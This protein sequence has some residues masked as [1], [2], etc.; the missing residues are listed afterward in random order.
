MDPKELLKESN[1]TAVNTRDN[2]IGFFEKRNLKR[3]GH[4]DCRRNLPRKDENGIWSAPYI[5]QQKHNYS[6]L[7]NGTYA[8]LQYKNEPVYA[9]LGYLMEAIPKDSEECMR[10]EKEIEEYSSQI[11]T[12]VRKNGES[13]LT[14]AQ[15]V[16]RRTAEKAKALAPLKERQRAV[17]D[18]L[19]SERDEF[20][21]L[22][23]QV[24]EDNNT[25]RLLCNKVRDHI[26]QRIAVYWDAA[27][28][29]DG[30]MPAAPEVELYSDAEETYLAPHR[31]FLE[32]V[33]KFADEL[34]HKEVK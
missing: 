7:T 1:R 15:V 21:R 28:N 2:S 3:I 11:P 12:N 17:K 19:K 34:E 6:E 8:A 9:R 20:M 16:S 31:A 14:D 22:R 25:C 23:N 30:Q 13:K 33:D 32:E 4:A 18:K 29:P 24:K 10:V 27:L 5:N 26:K